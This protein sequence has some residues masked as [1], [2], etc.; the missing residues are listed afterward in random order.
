MQKLVSFNFSHT[1]YY[2]IGL[3]GIYTDIARVN[4]FQLDH[5]AELLKYMGKKEWSSYME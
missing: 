1:L 2:D 5:R 4:V 3:I